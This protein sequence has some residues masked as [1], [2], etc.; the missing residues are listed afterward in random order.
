V[1][2]GINLARRGLPAV[3]LITEKF[4][5]QSETVSRGFGMPEIP[6]VRLPYPT[7]GRPELADIAAAAADDVLA[8]LQGSRP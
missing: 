2:D 1:R 4:W 8:A 6:R 5:A 7:A 3:A